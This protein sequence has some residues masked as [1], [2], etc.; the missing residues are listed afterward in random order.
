MPTLLLAR[1]TAG[2]L[3]VAY[4]PRGARAFATWRTLRPSRSIDHT[5]RTS[6]CRRTPSFSIWSNAGTPIPTFG[7]ADAVTPI[8]LEISQARCSATFSRTAV[9]SQVR[10]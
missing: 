6:N 5:I 8:R 2:P 4:R 1:N 3:A 7:T 10:S 9:G